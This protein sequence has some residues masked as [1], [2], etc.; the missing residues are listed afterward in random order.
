[1]QENGTL[2]LFF[3]ICANIDIISDQF[4][5]IYIY[6]YIYIIFLDQC[7]TLCGYLIFAG[8]YIE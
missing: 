3:S 5:Y 2:A 8:Y 4:I 6:I 7:N 1:V